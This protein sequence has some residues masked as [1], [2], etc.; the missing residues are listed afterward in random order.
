MP[1]RSQYQ[2]MAKGMNW[3][4]WV[5]SEVL[6]RHWVAS[7]ATRVDAWAYFMASPLPGLK[8]EC[9]MLAGQERWSVT[10]FDPVLYAHWHAN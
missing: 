2:K 6:W 8:I 9:E 10:Q 1:C 3:H 7:F 5:P 4:D